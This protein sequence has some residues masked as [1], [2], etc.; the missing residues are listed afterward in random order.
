LKQPCTGK[1]LK[2][3]KKIPLEWSRQYP[4]SQTVHSGPSIQV[5]QLLK[6]QSTQDVLAKNIKMDYM[7]QS[8][9]KNQFGKG[10]MNYHR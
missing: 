10:N 7:H 9:D 3:K 2:I 8:Q 4:G 1:E 6:E 5:W